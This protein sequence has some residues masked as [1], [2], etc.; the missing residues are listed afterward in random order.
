M[1]NVKTHFDKHARQYDTHRTRGLLGAIVK[2]EQHIVL[3]H[4]DTKPKEHILDAGCGSGYLSLLIKQRGGIPFGVDLSP[5]MI[6]QLHKHNI[7]GAVQNIETLQLNKTFNKILCAGAL[8]F[9]HN[10]SLVIKGFSE[11]LKKNGKL[12]ILY[13]RPSIGGFL[14][15]L[16]HLL[17]GITITLFSTQHMRSLLQQSGFSLEKQHSVDFIASVLKA[18]KL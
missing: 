17:H 6:N 15:K 2:K 12:V 9:A 11:H 7:D 1:R 4:L 13:P 5:H 10:P 3:Y 16:Y 14:Y 18:R 8:E